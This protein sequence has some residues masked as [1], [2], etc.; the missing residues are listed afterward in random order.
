MSNK[1]Y[2]E[3]PQVYHKNKKIIY[4]SLLII[5][6][7][8]F[9]VIWLDIFM[10][11]LKFNR[12]LHGMIEGRDYYIEEVTITKKDTDS[13]YGTPDSSVATTNYFFY[14]DT[15][16]QK[17]LFVDH[18][19]YNEFKVGDK[20][21]AYTINHNDYAYTKDGLLLMKSN[22]RNNEIKKAIGVILG[23]VL[24]LKILF[25]LLDKKSYKI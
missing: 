14:Y 23:G 21:P 7:L 12:E 20:I 18:T 16:F 15:S 2:K 11:S 5:L 10:T 1:L 17:K 3:K 22:Y 13:Y 19:T 24:V 8:A 6:C 9:V 25:G 4:F